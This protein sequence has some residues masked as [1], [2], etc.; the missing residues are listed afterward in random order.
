MWWKK[1]GEKSL[2]SVSFHCCGNFHLSSA[3]RSTT[4]RN[5]MTSKWQKQTLPWS[6]LLFWCCLSC[7]IENFKIS[8]FHSIHPVERVTKPTSRSRRADSFSSKLFFSKSDFH[9][10]YDFSILKKFFFFTFF[11]ATRGEIPKP[12]SLPPFG[13]EQYEQIMEE[14]KKCL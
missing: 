10:S 2:E 6:L 5:I 13:Y 8:S 9:I 4:C 14:M 7:R 12:F 1:N 11:L 3:T